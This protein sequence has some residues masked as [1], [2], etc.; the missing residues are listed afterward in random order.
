MQFIVD[1]EDTATRDVH[2]GPITEGNAFFLMTSALDGEPDLSSLPVDGCQRR[3]GDTA[4][5]KFRTARVSKIESQ[6]PMIYR[7]WRIA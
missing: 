7:V 2:G 3:K 1:N 6:R 5:S 4:D